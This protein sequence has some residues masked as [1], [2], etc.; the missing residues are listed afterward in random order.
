[1]NINKKVNFK[2]T[3][4]VNGI[5]RAYLRNGGCKIDPKSMDKVTYLSIQYSHPQWL[6]ER[7]IEQFGYEATKQY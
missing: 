7:Y 4:F 6:V 3:G 5:L 1:M 2:S